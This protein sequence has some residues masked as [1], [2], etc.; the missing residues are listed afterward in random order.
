MVMGRVW[1]V[2]R[3]RTLLQRFGF[4][5]LVA[6]AVIGLVL[7]QML[8]TSVQ[9]QALEGAIGQAAVV[10]R[11]GLQNEMTPGEVSDGLSPQRVQAMEL[12]LQVEYARIDVVDV[13]VWNLDRTVVFATNTN[14][15]GETTT[16]D[17]LDRALAGERLAIV[18]DRTDAEDA[19]PRS[20]RQSRVVEVYQP[21]RFGASAGGET[22]GVVRTSIPYGP[23]AD[24]IAA[25]TRRLYLALAGALVVLY[26]VLFRLVANASVE[27]RRQADENAQQARHDSLTNLP[28]RM[29]FT[30]QLSH[31]LER[32]SN[33]VAIVLIDLDRFKEVN[34]TLGHHHGDL[35]LIEIGHRLTATLRPTDVVARL[36]GDEFALVLADVKDARHA[37][38]VANRIVSAIEEPFEVEGLRL[39]VGASAG[40]AMSPQHGDDLATLL[41]RSDIAMYQAKRSGSRCALYDPAHDNN[42][43]QQLALAGELRL[44]MADQLVVHYQPKLDLV[45]DRV[46][47]M[48]ALVRWEHSELGLLSPDKFV[49]LAERAGMMN[50]LTRVVLDQSLTQ[51]RR[52][53]DGGRDLHLAVNVSPTGLHDSGLADVVGVLLAEHGIPAERL[54]LEITETT[55]AADP[56]G[57]REVLAVLRERG[58]RISIDDFG[59][60]YSSLAVLRSLPVSE[61]KIDR[62]FVGDLTHP[63][64]SAIVNYSIQLGHML[65]LAIVA[66]G[67]EGES[68][69]QELR[70]LGCDMAQGFWFARPMPGDSA[71]SWM[72]ERD[73]GGRGPRQ[74]VGRLSVAADRG[75]ERRRGSSE[76]EADQ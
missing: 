12:T 11:L 24:A 16:S 15:I 66:E 29:L 5:S 50:E 13:V 45:T 26:M 32:N 49:P 65:G 31:I 33:P 48:E 6:V 9:R 36:G 74:D 10:S 41:Q 14:T 21:L 44:S 8:R 71:T 47:G 56:D 67:V 7:G 19:D 52:W 62:R 64:G 57:A 59:T 1:T 37:L 53:L 70:R 42:S 25:E 2:L 38:A 27:L 18:T 73:G 4:I 60:G 40:I 55:I 3:D 20:R 22:A 39:D 28:N 76:S 51:L 58:V 63:E 35:L 54:V 43:R 46:C 68:D 75:I 61:L 69:E 23:V 30:E 34:D 17:E 72:D